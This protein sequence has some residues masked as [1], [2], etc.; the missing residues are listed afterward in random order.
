M[1]FGSPAHRTSSCSYCSAVG[2]CR[3]LG[4]VCTGLA[5]W[6]FVSSLR[7]LP[8]RTA[9]LV[10]SLEPVYAIAFAWVL[11]GQEP[12]LRTVIG[13]ALM[14]GAIFSASLAIKNAP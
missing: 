8:A 10:V 2:S 13:G 14:I 4:V 1:L 3:I 7:Q 12:S 9:G 5:H 6:L 11:F